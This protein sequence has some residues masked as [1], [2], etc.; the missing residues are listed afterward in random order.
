[1]DTSNHG[2]TIATTTN[3]NTNSN[4][5]NNSSNAGTPNMFQNIF[6]NTNLESVASSPIAHVESII[7][8]FNGSNNNNNNNNDDSTGTGSNSPITPSTNAFG[9]FLKESMSSSSSPKLDD[10][11]NNN[12]ASALGFKLDRQSIFNTRE[13][14]AKSLINAETKININENFKNFG[15]FFSKK[16]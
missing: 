4:N 5:N 12:G 11:N 14:L 10:N 7:S 9:N 8:N 16:N 13:N 6:N 2:G 3:G 15:K 1:M